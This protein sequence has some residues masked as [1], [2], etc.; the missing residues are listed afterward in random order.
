MKVKVTMRMIRVFR[1]SDASLM[2]M[3]ECWEFPLRTGACVLAVSEHVLK[4]LVD[5][6]GFGS[7]LLFGLTVI[8]ERDSVVVLFWL[9]FRVVKDV[10]MEIVFEE[11]HSELSSTL[12]DRSKSFALSETVE[13][14]VLALGLCIDC[15][16][17]FMSVDYPRPKN[18][19]CD[20]CTYTFQ[21]ANNS[22]SH[23]K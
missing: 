9:L 15:A 10:S 11:Q 5:V 20:T 1:F 3:P 21:Y 16:C 12:F 2:A 13:I 17:G 14:V 6:D 8:S 22:A 4:M 23:S 18:R 7:F 19:K